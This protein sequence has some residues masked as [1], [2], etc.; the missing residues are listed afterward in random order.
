MKKIRS[1]AALLIFAA[2]LAGCGQTPSSGSETTD[3]TAPSDTTEEVTEYA[4]PYPDT[5]YG[6]EEF[7]ILNMADMYTM[8]CGILRDELNGDVLNDAVFNRNKLIETKFDITLNETLVTDNWEL[9]TTAATAQKSILAGDNEFAVMFLPI[10]GAIGLITDGAFLDLETVPTVQLDQ[11][12][13]YDSFNRAIELGGKLYGAMGGAHLCI[14]DATRVLSFNDDMMERLGLDA[15]YDLV[16]E[17]KWTLDA[18]NTYLTAAANLN[19]DDSAAWKKDGKVVYGYSNNQNGIIKFLQGCGENIVEVKDGKLTYTAG[20]E[21]F[22]DCVSKLSKIFTTS[23]AKGINAPNGDDWK[24]DDGNPGYIYVFT[25]G[26][27]LFSGCEVNK[28]QGFRKLDFE[29]GIVPYPKYDEAQKTYFCDTWEGSPA[30]FIPVTS[31]DAEKA[32][33]ILDAMAYEGEKTAVPAFR[34]Y[35]VEQK[36]LRNEDSIEMLAIATRNIIPVY[37]S[38]FGIDSSIADQAGT[39][40]WTGTAS[41]SSKVASS[42]TKIAAQ[43][44]E[45]MEK[46]SGA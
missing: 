37:Y 34:D 19:G 8:H 12:W 15:P 46:W 5:G 29:Y 4:Y 6:G 30:A 31:A 42:E 41:I 14:H 11:P 3:V 45:I 27:A 18:M 13:W 24:D 2:M 28:F 39:D 9:K 1:A 44:A 17:G 40:V 21:R 32:G 38:I 10:K 33:L 7:G 36:G 16:R 22:Y 26:R 43:I 25:S 35:A 20:T 23:D